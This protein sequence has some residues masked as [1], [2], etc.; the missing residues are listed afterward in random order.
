VNPV[1]L[2]LSSNILGRLKERRSEEMKMLCYLKKQERRR[3]EALLSQ[4]MVGLRC[5]YFEFLKEK[6]SA[7]I[8][9]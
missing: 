3:E 6:K 8:T 7:N 9:C 4:K 5:I 2:L 1:P